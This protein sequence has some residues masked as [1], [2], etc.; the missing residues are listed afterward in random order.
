MIPP[1]RSIP[2]DYEVEPAPREI[3]DWPDFVEDDSF[4]PWSW[5]AMAA[6]AVVTAFGLGWL[7]LAVLA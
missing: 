5:G 7:I 1:V 3:G 2:L 4:G 6:G